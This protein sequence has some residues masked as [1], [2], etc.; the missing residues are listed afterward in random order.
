MI[1]FL[2]CMTGL[3][4]QEFISKDRQKELLLELGSLKRLAC[5]VMLM[6]YLLKKSEIRL[7]DLTCSVGPI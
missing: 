5:S 3:P 1:L 2:I 6:V 4:R 7:S